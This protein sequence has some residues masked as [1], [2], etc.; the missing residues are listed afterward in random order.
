[1]GKARFR[2]VEAALVMKDIL[3]EG[4]GYS[5]SVTF[6]DAKILNNDNMTSPGTGLPVP[7][8]V[9]SGSA[10]TA[11]TPGS[12]RVYQRNGRLLNGNFYPGIPPIKMRSV[13]TYA[14]T[15][16]MELTFASTYNSAA[17]QTIANIDWNH[18]T[19]YSI[20]QMVQFDMKA[21]WRF[22]KNWKA[23][24]GIDNIGNYKAF[25]FHP[26]AQRTF[27]AG[28]N[29]DFGGPADSLQ[30]GAQNQTGAWDNQSG[31]RYQ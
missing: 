19:L 8:W 28:I 7:L 18:N 12:P 2:G 25:Y 27:F 31:T 22:E 15:K 14:P 13:F 26:L 1:L 16:D 6:T 23:S 20:S 3:I 29:Y 10:S 30:A 5:G 24:F 11:T 9:I 21:N 4:L 17:W